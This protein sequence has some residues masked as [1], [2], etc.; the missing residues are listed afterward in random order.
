MAAARGATPARAASARRAPA[1]VEAARA[2]E[3]PAG[4]HLLRRDPDQGPARAPRPH[5]REPLG[6]AAAARRGHGRST[7]T[8]RPP[9][10]R[11]C[12][13]L[14]DASLPLHYLHTEPSLTK[15]RNLGIDE[16]GGDVV[17]FLDDDVSLP[18][19]LFA[20]LERAFA[21]SVRRRSDR[22]G[23]RATP[24]A[25]RR[26]ALV[27]P[28]NHRARERDA[29]GPL[30][31]LRLS[32]LRPARRR[33][34]RRRVHAGLLHDRA[35]GAASTVRFDEM[36][37]AYA[38]AE[39]EDFSFRLS[40]RGRLVYLPDLIVV[41]T[42]SSASAPTTRATSAGSWSGTAA[43]SF[44]RTSAQTPRSRLR[45]RPVARGCSSGTG[46]LNREWRGALGLLEG[47]ARPRARAAALSVVRVVFVSPF[48]IRA[49]PSATS[50]SC[51]KGSTGTWI[52]WSPVSPT[53]RCVTELR[54]RGYPVEVVP[55][56]APARSR[57]RARRC[58]CGGSCAQLR[59]D[60]V[61][62]DGIKGALVVDPGGDGDARSRS[63]GSSATSAATGC[64]RAPSRAAARRSRPSAAR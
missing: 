60:V 62:G 43:T 32:T 45:V 63:S 51:S 57:S 41:R 17:V 22:L 13:G 33:A 21:D 55:T 64:S 27:G 15:Q 29:P 30:H 25:A 9:P 59:P 10:E 20:K 1:L 40:R 37:G 38:L 8:S 19:D 4:D 28:S 58:A 47:D 61:H 12:L 5:A 48:V 35:P 2:S 3:G 6:D 31:A 14:Q 56:S 50:R 54:E 16:A 34:M 39:D 26:A 46:S 44:A 36:L 7:P 53:G 23:G 18:S 42:R 49:A 24:G 11:S 52:A